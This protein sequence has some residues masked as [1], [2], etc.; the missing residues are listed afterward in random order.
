MKKNRAY[1]VSRSLPGIINNDNHQEF[2]CV[3]VDYSAG[4]T[5]KNK[6]DILFS[7]N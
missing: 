5:V 2:E 4:M 7:M 6:K 1:R 3:L